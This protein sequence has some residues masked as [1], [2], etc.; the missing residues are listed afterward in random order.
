M[1]NVKDTL[2]TL[3]EYKKAFGQFSSVVSQRINVLDPVKIELDSQEE[4]LGQIQSIDFEGGD[5]KIKK[6]GAYLIFAAPQVGKTEG[7]RNRWIDFWL[8]LNGKD[9]D[10]STVRRV[11]TNKEEKDVVPLNA[12]SELNKGDVLNVMMAAET[13]DEGLGIEYIQPD[14]QPAIPSIIVTLVQL[15]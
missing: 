8:R 12:V 6:S 1:G 13:N 9:M 4:V 5:I 2:E 7:N 10:N 3:R 15:D 14:N 11:L